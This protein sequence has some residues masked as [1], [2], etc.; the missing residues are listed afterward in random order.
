MSCVIREF[1]CA[2]APRSF[3]H[4]PPDIKACRRRFAPLSANTENKLLIQ[5]WFSQV[6]QARV[7]AQG[8]TIGIIIAAGIMTH[9]QRAKAYQEE[10]E[11]RVR[12]LVSAVIEFHRLHADAST[13]SLWTIRGKTCSSK[14]YM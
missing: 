11:R 9:Q 8:L 6:V 13:I 7:W 12:H 3:A 10:D 2:Y 1:G 14:N 5:L 4:I